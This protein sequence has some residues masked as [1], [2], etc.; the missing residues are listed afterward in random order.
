[1]AS[2]KENNIA[3]DHL[4]KQ[5]SLTGIQNRRGYTEEAEKLIENNRKAKNNTLVAYVDMN[6]LKIVNDRYGHEE[7]DYSLK[8]IS[9]ILTKIT[10]ERGVVGRIGGD[11]Y[12]FALTMDNEM[13]GVAVERRIHSMFTAHNK[14]SDKPYNVTVSVG[15]YV[16]NADSNVG[17]D[18]AL[19]FADEKLYV[20]KQNKVNAVDK[21][22]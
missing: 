15:F 6:N 11:E 1:M 5:D 4:S 20:A 3:L 8:L 21:V 12:S 2:L 17:L 16:I 10:E 19:S 22:L 18:E 9:S 14:G 13:D 7:G